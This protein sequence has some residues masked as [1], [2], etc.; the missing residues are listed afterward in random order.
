MSER[1]LA[2]GFDAPS[3]QAR[4]SLTEVNPFSLIE[5]VNS[6]SEIAHTGWLIF[7]GVVAYF[8]IAAAGVTHK[9]LLLNSAVQ[10]PVLQV[11]IDLTRFFLFAPIVLVFMHFG[12]LVQHVMLA[13]KVME[14][15]A[16]VRD[17][18]P[19]H[20]RTHPIRHELHSY[21]FTQ[22]LA[23]PERSKLFGGFLHGM[24]WL[25]IIGIPVLVILFIQIVY[26]PY[27]DVTT[28]WSHRLALVL[29]TVI[30]GLMGA[31]LGSRSSSF[32]GAL[33]RMVRNQPLNVMATV[34]LYVGVVLFSFL[35]A[36]V[37]D[38]PLDRFTQSLPWSSV[39]TITTADGQV[40]SRR[41][42][43]VTDWLFEGLGSGSRL[44]TS[45]FRRNLSVTD[46]VVVDRKGGGKGQ[47]IVSL[48]DRDLRYAELDRSDLGLA[49]FTGAD[50]RGA[51]LVG[52][53]LRGA[54]LSCLDIDV[55]LTEPTLRAGSC[56]NLSSANFARADLS[57]ADLRFAYVSGANFENAVLKGTDFRYAD[58]TGANL[59]GADLRGASLGGGIELMGAN[60]L[61]ANLNGAD[62]KGARLQGSDFYG[63][64][65]KGARLVFAQ[66]QGANFQ[67]AHLEGANLNAARLQG[68]DF[69]DA[70]VSAVDFGAAVIWDT[71]PPAI[72]QASLADFGAI[73]IKPLDPKDVIALKELRKSV[74]LAR[75]Q[76][77]ID[78]LIAR[79]DS[80]EEG[81]SWNAG[82]QATAWAA[83]K[84]A[85]VTTDQSQ[86]LEKMAAF[87][88]K[89]SC[90]ANQ[91]D[92]SVAIGLV[93][94]IVDTPKK[95]NPAAM[96]RRL[97]SPDCPAA[98]HLP[99]L[100]LLD[101]EAT[102]E[103]TAP[104]V[105]EAAAAQTPA[106]AVT[107]SNP[108]AAAAVPAQ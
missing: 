103:R 104:M 68:A 43:A 70:D 28:T 4:P 71:K 102:T 29:D 80:A 78:K 34:I 53:N 46:E 65:L 18:E 15:D 13:R 62:L 60:F 30:L 47:A 56:A 23:G 49:D 73:V 101:L 81:A 100:V 66:A 42:F 22:A 96:L 51:R 36:T 7:L 32:F 89:L 9:D 5:A 99:E 19:T 69:T 3:P 58:L 24:F 10:L 64:D 97:R 98:K 40:A 35:V 1:S 27:H 37:P 92:G 76:D 48:R 52:T 57:G 11:S 21:F 41:V 79:F 39:K 107:D 8:C 83:M 59:S 85:A 12:L 67:G 106:A 105:A 82:D 38:E 74:K 77:K 20:R 44:S 45:P 94:R 6:T 93:R 75:V 108:A 14:F 55:V 25:S 50:L 31:F 16:A 88:G 87:F 91:S 61:G 84:Q 72:G 63:A 90:S 54:R 33:S 2:I 86:R 26:L 95:S 17:M